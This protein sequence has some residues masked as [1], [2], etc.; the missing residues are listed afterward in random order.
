MTWQGKCSR[1]GESVRGGSD[2]RSCV[3]IPDGRK[4]QKAVCLNCLLWPGPQEENHVEN[5]STE[6]V[7]ESQ[8]GHPMVHHLRPE[9]GSVGRP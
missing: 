8:M 6:L 9:F 7:F 4:G 1:C 3:R 5:Q 2:D